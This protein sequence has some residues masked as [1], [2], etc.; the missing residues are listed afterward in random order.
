MNPH[1]ASTTHPRR[2][3]LLLLGCVL[4][5]TLLGGVGLRLTEYAKWQA[6]GLRVDG[7]YIQ[8]T[9]DA[10]RWLAGAAGQ[11]EGQ[12]HPMARLAALGHEL[13]GLPLGDVGFFAPILP[14]ALAGC[15][16]VL[17]AWTLGALEAGLLAG[18]CTV[19][20]PAYLFRTRLGY[21]D[22]DM[23][24]LLF[25]LLLCWGLAHWLRPC[26][27][28][29][30]RG[31]ARNLA[32]PPC[33]EAGFSPL[34]RFT[35]LLLLGLFAQFAGAWHEHI[36][37]FTLVLYGM[38]VGLTLLASLPN[39]RTR[40]LWGLCG[41]GLCAWGGL[42]GPAV[43]LGGLTAL[44]LVP[45]RCAGLLGRTW[46]GLLL[47]TALFIQGGACGA[48]WQGTAR[49]LEAYG[50]LPRQQHESALAGET[51]PAPLLV[52]EPEQV[53]YPPVLPSI[54]EAQRID[55]ER[56]LVRIH[57][58]LW[59]AV[60][61]LLGFPLL[62]AFRPLA[63]LLAPLYVLGL[64]PL[65]LGGRMA[66]FATPVAALG[67]ALPLA[68]G[69]RR[70]LG[71]LPLERL[72]VPLLHGL[73][74]LCTGFLLT[75]ILRLFPDLPPTPVLREAH[76]RA[77]RELGRTAPA[78]A[79]VWTW[80]DWGYA[81]RYY[82]GLPSFADGGR[83]YG[84]LVYP[85]GFV[86]TT[87]S[88][89][90]ARQLMTFS[91]LQDYAPW[92]AW[93][94]QPAKEV[95]TGL[96]SFLSIDYGLQPPLPQ[97]LVVTVENLPLLYWITWYGNWDLVSR[98]SVHARVTR[99]DQAF[100]LDHEQGRILV[101]TLDLDLPLAAI[102]SLGGER[103]QRRTYPWNAGYSCVVEEQSGVAWLLD[104]AAYQSLAVQLLLD[105]PDNPRIAR[106]F[107]LVHDGLPTV[108]IY[109]VRQ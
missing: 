81:T 50:Q 95:K 80:W 76:A 19:L 105:D 45:Q 100:E 86:L 20:A 53:A 97:Y 73:L 109:E 42:W 4:L 56:L 12:G 107:R 14:A 49:L 71:L 43:A 77:L 103:P 32:P 47:A 15:A 91:A 36:R 87:P 46:P 92:R 90:Q 26:L 10:Y 7:E 75:P 65:L 13:L 37:L 70:L 39:Q 52:P 31:S 38:T 2:G 59:P 60:A 57:P 85:L 8:A 67:L 21:Y 44:Q 88:P 69:L 72:R 64:T 28:P 11:G 93:R 33:S 101:P 29:G 58:W 35:P 9:H 106:N 40:T 89:L 22:T 99:I 61:G 30:W 16:V 79:M 23:V 68:W 41:F 34:R 1:C 6:P 51:Q 94:N 98:Q 63:T 5:A 96:Q 17:L 54:I 84:R 62:V 108:R 74:L 83:H 24:T 55:L 18:L 3:H 82:S 27:R 25:P 66:M 104:E 102:H 48:L 78:E